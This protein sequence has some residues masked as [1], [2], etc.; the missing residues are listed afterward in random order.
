MSAPVLSPSVDS[1]V[2]AKIEYTEPPKPLLATGKEFSNDKLKLLI[3]I[4]V[5]IAL[6]WGFIGSVELF[7]LSSLQYLFPTRTNLSYS[8]MQ[9][10]IYLS[11][12]FMVIYFTDFDASRLLIFNPP[13]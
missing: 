11:L 2:P 5:I 12:L 8:I 7:I 13:E 9:I 4:I 6:V 10:L 3:T 1:V